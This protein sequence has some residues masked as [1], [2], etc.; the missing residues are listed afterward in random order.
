MNKKMISNTEIANNVELSGP[1]QHLD[2]MQETL[3][4]DIE[5]YT[6]D[7]ALSSSTS[8]EAAATWSGFLME[9]FPDYGTDEFKW[10]KR[11]AWPL[12]GLNKE[13]IYNHKPQ[14]PDWFEHLKKEV[15][16]ELMNEILKEQTKIVEERDNEYTMEEP[17]LNR[18]T[19]VRLINLVISRRK[20]SNSSNLLPT[21][22][23][24]SKISTSDAAGNEVLFEFSGSPDKAAPSKA[25][26]YSDMRELTKYFWEK[27]WLLFKQSFY[28]RL[29]A[30]VV[31]DKDYAISIYLNGI[32]DGDKLNGTW[33]L[34]LNKAVEFELSFRNREDNWRDMRRYQNLDGSQIR[35]VMTVYREMRDVLEQEEAE[36]MDVFFGTLPLSAFPEL[37]PEI[38][39][40]KNQKTKS[41]VKK[42]PLTISTNVVMLSDI[43]TVHQRFS[44]MFQMEYS[45][46]QTING[47]R[48]Y[49]IK[50]QLDELDEMSTNKERVFKAEWKPPE[51]ILKN[52]IA[53]NPVKETPPHIRCGE[54]NTLYSNITYRATFSEKM[55]L[56][57]FPFDCQELNMSMEI[58]GND[59]DLKGKNENFITI[60]WDLFALDEWQPSKNAVDCR[61][62][63]SGSRATSNGVVITFKLQRDPS[64]YI[65]KLA[66]TSFM[67]VTGTF[68]FFGIAND[69]IADRLN[70]IA[71]MFLTG[72]A[73]QMVATNETPSLGYLSMIDYF[74]VIGNLF[75]YMQF[76]VAIFV[77]F[78]SS[79]SHSTDIVNLSCLAISAGLYA[80]FTIGW[81]IWARLISIPKE[82][83][84][85][86]A[87]Q[88]D[89]YSE[90][91]I[92]ILTYLDECDGSDGELLYSV[93]PSPGS[94]T[95]SFRQSLSPVVT[96][97]IVFSQESVHGKLAALNKKT[98]KI[99]QIVGKRIDDDACIFQI[100]S[101]TNL[102]DAIDGRKSQVGIIMQHPIWKRKDMNR[103]KAKKLKLRNDRISLKNQRKSRKSK[104]SNRT[105][106][107][108]SGQETYGMELKKPATV[109]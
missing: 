55:E 99:T 10:L 47:G 89:L 56:E 58:K 75:I 61:I 108:E 93:P 101:G 48:Y 57:N 46:K 74:L 94:R 39:F 71:T 17:H 72:Q 84:K 70:Y 14:A 92:Y 44:C 28:P 90:G 68:M 11:V 23:A 53:S 32:D 33:G 83:T 19:I 1:K 96:E 77:N 66:I 18:E 24:S 15:Q 36:L 85:L 100:L 64:N 76:V 67:I 40:Y 103:I 97:E 105:V 25:I 2:F 26:K 7:S 73:F 63:R 8:S 12:Y 6:S 4:F 59:F 16:Q 22:I 52:A 31:G 37:N 34:I 35:P 20:P 104:S 30:D 3:N 65:Y 98:L 78:E 21:L 41:N 62:E 106:A 27:K 45:W 69:D 13:R 38:G 107:R 81:I 50:E 87:T 95:S 80:A 42:R 88:L 54:Y 43:S 5:G 91:F 49:Y 60:D 51:P 109:F 82:A 29:W 102:L 86:N 79:R 9:R